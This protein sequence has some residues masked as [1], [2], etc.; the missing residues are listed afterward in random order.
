MAVSARDVARV[1]GVSISTV[2]RALAKPEDVAPA[3]RDKALDM[4]RGMGYRPN[5]A[6]I[7][8]ADLVIASAATAVLAFNDLVACGLLDRFRQPGVRVPD[9][10]S[11]VGMDNL[12]I[13][14]L[15][16]PSLT[17]V[18]IPLVNCGRAAVD[19]V[20]S[21]VKYPNQAPVHHHDL[22]SQLAVRQSTGVVNPASQSALSHQ[23]YIKTESLQ[24]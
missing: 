8:A 13:S 23:P 19:M 17:S 11:V 1:A 21:L 2:S 14:A 15:T 16:A 5:L 4:A 6:G 24:T 22:S 9:D 10:I 18:G 3:T 12:S 7:A 20:L